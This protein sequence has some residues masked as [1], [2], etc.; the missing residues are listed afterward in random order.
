MEV[1]VYC[2]SFRLPPLLSAIRRLSDLV[3]P[4]PMQIGDA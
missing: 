3:P 1:M 4:Q 2:A